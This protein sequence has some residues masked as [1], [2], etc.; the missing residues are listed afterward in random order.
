[1][2]IH[3][4]KEYPW[5]EETHFIEKIWVG[6]AINYF[7]WNNRNGCLSTEKFKEDW[8]YGDDHDGTS[9]WWRPF[10]TAKPKIHTIREDKTDR[11]KPE[12]IIHF[13]QWTGRPYHSKC[14]HF[15]PLIPCISTQ[16]IE[17]EYVLSKPIVVID[18]SYFY[19]PILGIDK[20]MLKLAN[21]DGFETIEDFFKW[22]HHDFS[23]KIIHWTDLIY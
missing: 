3:F 14:Y 11:W 8:P 6:F 21:N 2:Q 5:G 1:M 16:S 22:F 13:M 12:T 9:S 10:M 17:I 4:V 7:L 18:N 19:N 20:G 23:G 15:A